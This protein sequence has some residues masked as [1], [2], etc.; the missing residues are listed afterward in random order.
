MN[1]ILPPTIAFRLIRLRGAPA[2]MVGA[3]VFFLCLALLLARQFQ[4][5]D[6][7]ATS[8][9][10][11]HDPI[12]QDGNTPKTGIAPNADS[13]SFASDN[14]QALSELDHKFLDDLFRDQEGRPQDDSTPTAIPKTALAMNAMTVKRAELVVH[15]ETVK[16]AKLVERGR[17]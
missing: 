7:R 16:R 14:F 9:D 1:I 10:G 11:L 3:S 15:N 2:I 12:H 4:M 13:G 17:N 6:Q 5:I 8:S